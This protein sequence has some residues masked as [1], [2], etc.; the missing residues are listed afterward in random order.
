MKCHCAHRNRPKMLSDCFAW[1][2]WGGRNF[3]LFLRRRLY[4]SKREKKKQQ[5][6]KTED[7][8]SVIYSL[9]I[10]P[11]LQSISSIIS[12]SPSFFRLAH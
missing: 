11:V 6:Q 8:T 5:Q 1:H 7:S 4:I 3:F 2:L 12:K 10:I 9:I